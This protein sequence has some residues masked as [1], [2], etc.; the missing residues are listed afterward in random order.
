[1]E[2][3]DLSILAVVVAAVFGIGLGF[4]WYAPFL[5]GS[6]W[7]RLIGLDPNAMSGMGPSM[8]LIVL[9]GIISTLALAIIVAWSEADTE[10]NGAVVGLLVAIGFLATTAFNLVV[11]EKRPWELYLINNGYYV[12]S[13]AIQGAILVGLA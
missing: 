2:S 8:G 1:M 4:L 12:V 11:F 5:F 3:V 6:R 7:A 13:Y 9:G 10:L